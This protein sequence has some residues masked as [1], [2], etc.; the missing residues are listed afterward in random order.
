[1]ASSKK[2]PAERI[3]INIDTTP[4]LYTDNINI[5]VNQNGAVINVMQKISSNQ[6]KV[7]SRIGM[8]RE[9]AK[10]FVEKFGKLLIMTEGGSE[11]GKKNLN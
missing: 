11:T 10:E 9:H 3:S 8:S 7:V 1:M 6:K 5:S 2:T 4:I